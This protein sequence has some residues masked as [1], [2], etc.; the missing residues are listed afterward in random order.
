MEDNRDNEQKRRDL[1]LIYG[2]D[3]TCNS[4]SGSLILSIHNHQAYMISF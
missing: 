4:S 3:I 1:Q 2:R